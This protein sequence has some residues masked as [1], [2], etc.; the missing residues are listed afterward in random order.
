MFSLDILLRS[1]GSPPRWDHRPGG[2]PK[3]LL[4]ALQ[5]CPLQSKEL[6]S[7]RHLSHPECCIQHLKNYPQTK[8]AMPALLN[9][10]RGLNPEVLNN[11]K[12]TLILKP[13]P[14]HRHVPNC[15][16]HLSTLRVQTDRSTGFWWVQNPTPS[17]QHSINAGEIFQMFKLNHHF[18]FS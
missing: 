5:L 14:S 18:S 1:L 8:P 12:N 10:S 13:I 3:V 11:L 2:V 16:V 17:A 7:P 15:A 4:I 6:S 9:L